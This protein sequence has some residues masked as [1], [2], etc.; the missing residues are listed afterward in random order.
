MFKLS[1][2]MIEEYEAMVWMY[3]APDPEYTN[4]GIVIV[5]ADEFGLI[6]HGPTPLIVTTFPVVNTDD[7]VLG[8]IYI[9]PLFVIVELSPN[10]IDLNVFPEI[11]GNVKVTFD[12]V[13]CT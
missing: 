13:V 3:Q 12:P 4:D 7:V 6:N 10:T 2:L 9:F 8:V 5:M 1:T 11:V